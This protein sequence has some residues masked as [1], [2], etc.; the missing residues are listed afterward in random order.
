MDYNE[1]VLLNSPVL[2][3]VIQRENRTNYSWRIVYKDNDPRSY[4]FFFA[5]A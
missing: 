2:P 4:E 5:I 3:A 1:Y